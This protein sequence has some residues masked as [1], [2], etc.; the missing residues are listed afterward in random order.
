MGD[1]VFCEVETETA[2]NVLTNFLLQKVKQM[3]VR[4]V[5]FIIVLPCIIHISFHSKH[6]ERQCEYHFD[7][8]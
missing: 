1:S 7:W 8:I 3:S 6:F 5:G 4:W 2:N